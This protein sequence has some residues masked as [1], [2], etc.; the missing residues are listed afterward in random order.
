MYMLLF[1]SLNKI[2]IKSL[3][4]KKSSS[5]RIHSKFASA[6]DVVRARD[7]ESP[8]RQ[9]GRQARPTRNF[10]ER[11]HRGAKT[12]YEY[13]ETDRRRSTDARPDATSGRRPLR[14]RARVRR[15]AGSASG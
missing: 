7:G 1:P 2:G 5:E 10:G 15:A 12:S 8:R 14:S 3:A 9:V 6:R 11:A 13:S 4:S